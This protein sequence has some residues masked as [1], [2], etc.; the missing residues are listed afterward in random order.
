MVI[1]YHDRQPFPNMWS[2]FEDEDVSEE[3]AVTQPRANRSRTEVY[4]G[5]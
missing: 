4:S 5:F 3:A 2:A 1:P